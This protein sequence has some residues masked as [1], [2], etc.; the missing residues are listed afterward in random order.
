MEIIKE[1]L[2]G[3]AALFRRGNPDSRYDQD[4]WPA[5]PPGVTDHLGWRIATGYVRQKPPPVR[6]LDLI[7][8]DDFE[9]KW[10]EP[11]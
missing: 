6:R 10:R 4:E 8:R 7:G 3:I 2:A 5:I 1:T 9:T 11:G